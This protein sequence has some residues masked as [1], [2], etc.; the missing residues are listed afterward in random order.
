MKENEETKNQK[1][2]SFSAQKIKSRKKTLYSPQKLN[3]LSSKT[4]SRTHSYNNSFYERTG[5]T[6]ARKIK[7]STSFRQTRPK[8]ISERLTKS[9]KLRG[10]KEK[11]IKVDKTDKINSRPTSKVLKARKNHLKSLKEYKRVIRE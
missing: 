5:I 7:N 1:K 6:K 2:L 11:I 10:L 3:R 4:R 9:K 8:R